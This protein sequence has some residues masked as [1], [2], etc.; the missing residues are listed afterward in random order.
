MSESPYVHSAAEGVVESSMGLYSVPAYVS[1]L[2]QNRTREQAL[3]IYEQRIADALAIYTEFSHAFVERCCP[4]CGAQERAD[5]EPFQGIYRVA[6]CMRCTTAYVTPCPPPA[7]LGHYY[8][9]CRCNGM[10]G[11]LLKARQRSGDRIISDRVRFLLTLIDE[12]LL[13]RARIR[14]LEV[15]CNSGGLLSELKAAL[16][17]SD[18]LHRCE[19]TGID[20]DA[21]AIARNEDRDLTL[22][23]A[24][25]E[26]FAAGSGGGS[27]ISS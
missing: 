11:D 5:L 19:L 22:H 24:S 9:Q 10:L 3:A 16:H 15:G 2:Q 26:E 14:I 1:F 21:S 6:K 20:I 12:Y 18:L 27:S 23:A 4:C 8:S 7:V 25:A 13:G 17:A